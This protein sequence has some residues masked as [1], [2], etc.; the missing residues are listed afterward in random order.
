[1]TAPPQSLGY[2]SPL[3]SCLPIERN[4]F[5]LPK[6]RTRDTVYLELCKR[7]ELFYDN[8]QDLL[9]ERHNR[10]KGAG[11]KQEG[12]FQ[13][14]TTQSELP[15]DN[16][17]PE[18][19]IPSAVFQGSQF[20]VNSQLPQRIQFVRVNSKS[21]AKLLEEVNGR[22]KEN[23]FAVLTGPLGSGKTSLAVEYAHRHKDCYSS[24]FWL[25]AR[26]ERTL[27]SSFVKIAHELQA[28]Y[29]SSTNAMEMPAELTKDLQKLHRVRVGKDQVPIRNIDRKSM[30]LTVLDWFRSPGNKEWLLIY[31]DVEHSSAPF[32]Q[33]FLPA[34]KTIKSKRGYVLITSRSDYSNPSEFSEHQIELSY[35]NSNSFLQIPRAFG[36]KPGQESNSVADMGGYFQDPIQVGHFH[37]EESVELLQR[38]FRTHRSNLIDVSKSATDASYFGPIVPSVGQESRYFKDLAN[39][40]QNNPLDVAHAGAFISAADSP[41]LIPNM[42][43]GTLDQIAEIPS[44]FYFWYDACIMLGPGPIPIQLVQNYFHIDGIVMESSLKVL[45]AKGAIMRP[46]PSSENFEVLPDSL[47]YR[48]QCLMGERREAKKYAE[49][50]CNSAVGYLEYLSADANLDRPVARE[51]EEK[52]ILEHI[53]TCLDHCRDYKDI[54]CEWDILARLCENYGFYSQASIFYKAAQGQWFRNDVTE[55]PASQ[56]QHSNESESDSVLMNAWLSANDPVRNQVLATYSNPADHLFKIILE[57]DTKKSRKL[58]SEVAAIRMQLS[59]IDFKDPRTQSKRSIPDSPDRDSGRQ[60]GGNGG[61]PINPVKACMRILQEVE[62]RNEDRYISLK[63]EATQQIVRALKRRGDWLGAVRW[64]RSLISTLEI[65]VGPN[66]EETMEAIQQMAEIR[67]SQS[68]FCG[69][70]PLL[71]QVRLRYENIYDES[72]RKNIEVVELLSRAYVEQGELT[73]ARDLCRRMVDVRTRDLGEQHIETASAQARLAEVYARLESKTEAEEWYGRALRT[74]EMFGKD[75]SEFEEISKNR[76]K[77]LGKGESSSFCE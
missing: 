32:L 69:A 48:R 72:H 77:F 66:A 18:P 60:D 17:G 44:E 58:R 64:N 2:I 46:G 47:R 61:Q 57:I 29:S 75:T 53:D 38:S 23:R 43:A 51:S 26:S 4:H 30:V 49:I 11:R 22:L 24:V 14:V 73:T 7:I 9:G 36:S 13:T 50:A 16:N 33:N 35:S 71:E 62:G 63:A 28:H 41:N 8:A 15:R 20:V 68:D 21:R 52:T 39:T 67:M 70:S 74:A 59:G 1:M 19:C 54:L 5:D 37:Q 6:F 55:A 34:M 45:E 42:L 12:T 56:G 65:L 31:D 76:R 27:E 25:D 10:R 40:L 3:S